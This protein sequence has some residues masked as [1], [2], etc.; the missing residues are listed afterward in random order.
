MAGIFDGR[1]RSMF[2]VLAIGLFMGSCAGNEISAPAHQAGLGCV[3][4]SAHCISE[5]GNSL[6]G[7]MADK[8]K[9]WIRQPATPAAY[10]SGVRIW[11]FKQ[12][13]RE[14]SWRLATRED[15]PFHAF[16]KN[17]RIAQL[18]H[19]LHQLPEKQQEVL[20]LYYFEELTMKEIAQSFRVAESR[21]SQ[22]HTMAVIQLRSLLPERKLR[23][24][25][26]GA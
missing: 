22:I 5:R 26:K 18:T 20:T 13:K 2:A 24:C 15:D 14:L 6:K 3:D 8:S 9:S 11:A 17:E 12:K 10:A 25:V 7:L 19:A 21:I 4:D 23:I 1:L 16:A